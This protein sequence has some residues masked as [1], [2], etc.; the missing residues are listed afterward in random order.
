MFALGTPRDVFLQARELNDIG[1]GI[2]AAQRMANSLREAGVPI[3]GN[4]LYDGET[5]A[6][7]LADIAGGVR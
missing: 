6:R 2:P 4:V 7:V 1:L 5:L 3:P